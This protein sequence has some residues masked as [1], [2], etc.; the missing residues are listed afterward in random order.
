MLA[1]HNATV[2]DLGYDRG[3]VRSS[4]GRIAIVT[5]W[6]GGCLHEDS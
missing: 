1:F 4:P 6:M 3:V 2:S 5:S